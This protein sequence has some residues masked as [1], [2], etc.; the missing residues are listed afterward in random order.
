MPR[1]SQSADNCS[2]TITAEGSQTL[3]LFETSHTKGWWPFWDTPSNGDKTKLTVIIY[4]LFYN[5][6]KIKI[7]ILLTC[8]ESPGYFSATHLK[9]EAIKI[10]DRG[11]LAC[12]AV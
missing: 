7:L 12:D 3:D 5:L 11:L 4:R 2:L 6:N 10:M 8:L 1:G 9:V